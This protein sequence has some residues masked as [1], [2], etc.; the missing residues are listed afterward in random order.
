VNNLSKGTVIT[1][2]VVA[3]LLSAPALLL[4]TITGLIID[5]AIVVVLIL[6]GLFVA[7][8][9]AG[10]KL[11]EVIGRR[12]FRTRLGNRMSRSMI[13]NQAKRQGVSLTDPTGRKLSDVELQLQMVD[14][15]ETRQI[16]QQL[17]RMNPQQ[18]A[19]AL[20]LME[21]QMLAAQRGDVSPDIQAAARTSPGFQPPRASGRPATR[22]P[23]SKSRKGRR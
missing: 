8:T 5:L 10:R 13:R 7:K 15:P 16:K 14:T 6:L 21:A 22:A 19:Q 2:L 9:K 12:L 23:R 3:L 11:G 4:G 1:V 18:R 17:K 20:R